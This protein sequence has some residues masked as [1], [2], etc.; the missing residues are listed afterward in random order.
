M[1][2][3]HL[4]EVGLLDIVAAA[5]VAAAVAVAG[6]GVETPH[7]ISVR[8][9]VVI[10]PALEYCYL[11]RSQ[12]QLDENLE[13]KCQSAVGFVEHPHRACHNPYF[14]PFPRLAA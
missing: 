10:V 8:T 14:F 3:L 11:R 2:V 5:V 1:A 9:V 6:T 12:N 4:K 7:Y 13:G